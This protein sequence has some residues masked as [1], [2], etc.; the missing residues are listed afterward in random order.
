MIQRFAHA[1]IQIE[2]SRIII[3]KANQPDIVVH[4]L[5]A[6]RLTSK[7][8]LKL[9]AIIWIT[10][11]WHSGKIGQGADVPLQWYDRQHHGTILA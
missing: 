1:R 4:F 10:P 2:V 5:D 8:M 7:T 9:W 11:E 6:D 3:H